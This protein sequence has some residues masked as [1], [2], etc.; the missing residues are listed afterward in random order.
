VRE[1][2]GEGQTEGEKDREREIETI[3]F[4]NNYNEMNTMAYY[5]HELEKYFTH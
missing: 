5:I 1:R 2:E 3:A 4:G